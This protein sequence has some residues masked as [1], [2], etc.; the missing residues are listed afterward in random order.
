MSNSSE[1]KVLPDPSPVFDSPR[2]TAV[3]CKWNA[4]RYEHRLALLDSIIHELTH[5]LR[6]VPS[7]RLLRSGYTLSDI[8]RESIAAETIQKSRETNL[9]KSGRFDTFRKVLIKATKS[10]VME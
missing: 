9:K 6:M 4:V 1:N 7:D 8:L 10:G 2:A 5:L 3:K